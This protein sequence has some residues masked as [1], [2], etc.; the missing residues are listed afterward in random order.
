MVVMDHNLA[1]LFMVM[2]SF[3][4]QAVK[5]LFESL[6]SLCAAVAT[7]KNN[8]KHMMETVG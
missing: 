7:L 4:E 8:M 2:F 1:V 5:Q 6:K 3:S